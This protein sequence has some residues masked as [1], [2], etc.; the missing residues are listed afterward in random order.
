MQNTQLPG[1]RIRKIH[2]FLD[3]SLCRV[4]KGLEDSGDGKTNMRRWYEAET[5]RASAV[6]PEPSARCFVQALARVEPVPFA[7][8]HIILRFRFE[9]T[10]NYQFPTNS[11]VCPLLATAIDRTPTSN[12][13]RSS[14]EACNNRSRDKCHDTICI[15]IA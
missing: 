6:G 9:V 10:N 3:A 1:R 12:F 4:H 7:H 11:S 14:P 13:D 2:N 8:T 15:A 5:S